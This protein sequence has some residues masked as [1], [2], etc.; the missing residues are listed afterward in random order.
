MA[1]WREALLAQAVI[2]GETRGYKHHPQL[3]RFNERRSSIGAI[4]E[5]LRI[6]HAESLQ[7]GYEF[8]ADKIH[9]AR[10]TE[11]IA[12]TRGQVE[13]EWS[14]L[15]TKLATRDPGRMVML[16]EVKRPAVHPL[17]RVVPGDVEIWERTR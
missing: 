4:G 13:F 10:L 6:V 16:K 2:L 7:R 9:K 15:M 11:S 14:H 17:F 1:L 12:A 8:A 5:Y 3:I